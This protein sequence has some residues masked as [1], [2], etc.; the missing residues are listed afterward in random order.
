MRCFE[1][2]LVCFM[3]VVN[4]FTVFAIYFYLSLFL[5]GKMG[6]N[7]EVLLFKKKIYVGVCVLV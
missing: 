1:M 5:A 7:Y 2:F 3:K 4:S 6:L